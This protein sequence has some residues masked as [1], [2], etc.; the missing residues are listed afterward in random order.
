M[1]E[2]FEIRC[3]RESMEVINFV[4]QS[5][6]GM[7]AKPLYSINTLLEMVLQFFSLVL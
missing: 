4:P 3:E 7:I 2:G 6:E 5:D 1:V